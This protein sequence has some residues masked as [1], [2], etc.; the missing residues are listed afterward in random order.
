M[1]DNRFIRTLDFGDV[2]IR[3]HH[4]IGTWLRD[5]DLS[6]EGHAEIR[7]DT[8]TQQPFA[9]LFDEEWNE[10]PEKE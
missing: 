5:I 6:G 2:P 1:G 8:I 9:V 3:R 4:N 7:K 10:L